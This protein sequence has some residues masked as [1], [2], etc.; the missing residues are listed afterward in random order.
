MHN[1][2]TRVTVNDNEIDS[3]H[4]YVNFDDLHCNDP[5]LGHDLVLVHGLDLGLGLVLDPDPVL[6]LD[7]DFVVDIVSPLHDDRKN[8]DPNIDKIHDEDNN[9]TVTSLRLK[10][11]RNIRLFV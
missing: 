11:R 3:F 2:L 4:H 7:L 8:I 10:E 6:D 1:D 5:N 9:D